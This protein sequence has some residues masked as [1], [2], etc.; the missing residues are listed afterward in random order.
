MMGSSPVRQVAAYGLPGRA[1]I[2]PAR[3]LSEREW[4]SFLREIDRHRLAGLLQAAVDAGHF[5]VTERQARAVDELHLRWCGSSLRLE[6][7][8]LEL[9]TVFD[10]AGI[11]FLVLKGTA[12]AH[13]DY[14]DPAL[15]LFGDVDL[16][17]R[18]EQFERALTVMSELGYVR[19]VPEPRR[20]FDRRFGKGATLIGPD[21]ISMDTHRNLVFGTFGFAIH[22][23]EL[24]SSAVPFEL[25]GRTLLALGPECRLLHACYHAALGD[26]RPRYSSVRDVAQLMARRQHDPDR[27]LMLAEAWQANAVLRR[28]FNLCRDFLG[29]PVDGV[30]VETADAHQPSRR[31]RRAIASYVGPNRHWSRKVLA[32]LP[33]LRG[34]RLKAAFL[35]AAAFPSARFAEIRGEGAGVTWI[36]RGL[37]SLWNGAA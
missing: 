19:E 6:H 7:R 35:R 22:L 3:P 14:P 16:L 13:L 33:Y 29:V 30:E 20:G 32:S 4:S 23:E 27:L 18:S 8:L 37:R 2:F 36:R 34:L 17:F 11:E 12:V 21:R 9:A 28:A 5:P 10:A 26:P 1:A 31:E 15:R 24:F 25:G